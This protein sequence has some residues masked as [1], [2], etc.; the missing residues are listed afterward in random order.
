M[1]SSALPPAEA[2]GKGQDPCPTRLLCIRIQDN[3]SGMTPDALTALKKRMYTGTMDG[4]TESIGLANIH[5]RLCLLYGNAYS[6]R[7][8]SSP[9]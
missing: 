7:I 4:H 8:D 5:Q 6:I 1:P 3:G 2:S 9:L